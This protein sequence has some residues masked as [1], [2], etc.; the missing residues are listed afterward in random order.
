MATPI[1]LAKQNPALV[2]SKDSKVIVN[3]LNTLPNGT[4][5]KVPAGYTDEVINAG[6][7]VIK[8][9]DGDYTLLATAAGKFVEAGVDET[10]RGVVKASVL[11]SKPFVSIMDIGCVNFDAM[12]FS[13]EDILADLKTNLPTIVDNK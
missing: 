6:H 4:N 3:C 11:T 13:P 9:A 7:V 5:L 10:Y 2:G 8:D 12:P 1:N